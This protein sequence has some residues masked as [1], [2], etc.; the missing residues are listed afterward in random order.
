MKWIRIVLVVVSIILLFVIVYAIINSE[1]S[2]KYEIGNRYGDKVDI[3]WVEEWL[4]ETIKVWKLFLCYVI[5]NIFYLLA[6]FIHCNKSS[7]S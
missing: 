2:Y 4:K 5:I 3:S 1:I 7:N 6:S